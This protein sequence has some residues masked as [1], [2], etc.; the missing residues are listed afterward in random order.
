MKKFIFAS[1]VTLSMATAAFASDNNK[2]S[3]R[4]IRNFKIEFSNVSEVDWSVKAGLNT[5]S[6]VENGVYTQAFYDYDG[7]L[8]A[9]CKAVKFSDLGQKAK[10]AYDKKYADYTIKEVISYQDKD[11]LY[12]FVS[13]ENNQSKVILKVAEDGRLSLHQKT[14][15]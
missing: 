10:D 5:A 2:I 1:I 14:A 4:A 6:F 7:S 3:N 11:R 12:Y 8:V 15:R 13:A 9:T